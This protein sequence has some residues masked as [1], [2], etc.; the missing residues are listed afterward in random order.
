MTAPVISLNGRWGG[1]LRDQ[2][3]QIVSGDD[4][5]LEVTVFE[6]DGT[7]KDITGATINWGLSRRPGKDS[8]LS[9]TGT[10]TDATNGVFQIAIDGTGDLGGDYYHEAQLTESGGTIGTV[11]RGNAAI[12]LDTV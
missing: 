7:K 11:M 8:K 12:D 4:V 1:K 5:T 9:K 2:N 3:I 10:V 6:T